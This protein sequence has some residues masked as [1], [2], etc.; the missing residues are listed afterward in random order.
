MLAVESGPSG[1]GFA[2]WWHAM[3]IHAWPNIL[4]SKAYEKQR[5]EF[6]K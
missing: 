2:G 4:E 6:N 1:S 3:W 5:M